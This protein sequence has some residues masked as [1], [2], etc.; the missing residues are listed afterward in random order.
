MFLSV[1]V[2]TTSAHLPGYATYV[3]FCSPYTPNWLGCWPN[4]LGTGEGQPDLERDTL[5]EGGRRWEHG[6]AKG[7]SPSTVTSLTSML[8]LTKVSHIA[9]LDVHGT[10]S[11]KR[12]G[13]E[14]LPSDWSDGSIVKSTHCSSREPEFSSPC[15]HCPHPIATACNCS[16]RRSSA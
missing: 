12:E 15:L 5:M 1:R 11:T 3:S 6:A 8:S 10:G 4:L 16:S 9:R 7:S 2:K 13:L 14:T